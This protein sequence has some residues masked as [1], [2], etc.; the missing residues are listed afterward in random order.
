ML[1]IKVLLIDLNKINYKK[2]FK[3]LFKVFN[4]NNLDDYIFKFLFSIF[5]EELSKF[6]K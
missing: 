3:D 5:F 1:K 2:L 4:I 6:G